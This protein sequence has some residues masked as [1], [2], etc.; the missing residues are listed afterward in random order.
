MVLAE[1]TLVPLGLGESVSA[2]VAR[3]LNLVDQ[4]G[5]PY[6]L[7]AMGTLVEGEW[8]EVM[9]LVTQCYRALEPD[10]P[11]ISVSLRIDARRGPGGRLSSKV[12]KVE[13]TL[14]RRLSTQGMTNRSTG[15]RT[16][17]K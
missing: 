2:P 15:R 8:D 12:A 14:G 5:L 17:P 1:F 9:A 10:C 7:H 13:S 3:V 6:Q 11:R 16:G 4:S